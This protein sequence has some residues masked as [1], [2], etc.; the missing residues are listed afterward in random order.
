[1]E[2]ALTSHDP[3]FST[4]LSTVIV[5]KALILKIALDT[6]LRRVFDY[7]PPTPPAAPPRVG[8]GGGA[9]GES[10]R[11]GSPAAER[12]RALEPARARPPRARASG[13]GTRPPT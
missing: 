1:M 2:R 4:D 10:A 13:R 11:G 5:D 12:R 8:P 7:L 6:P 3:A 9:A